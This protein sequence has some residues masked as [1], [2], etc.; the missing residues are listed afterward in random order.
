MLNTKIIH[1][2]EKTI[3]YYEDAINS[4]KKSGLLDRSFHITQMSKSDI[5][6]MATGI[7]NSKKI[8]L[9]DEC[10]HA[11]VSTSM[12]KVTP[13]IVD[14]KPVLHKVFSFIENPKLDI[15]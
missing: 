14:E 13:V 3:R 7:D 15:L 8:F 5:G 6:I 4:M 11:E 1:V 12:F 10:G 9:W 2:M